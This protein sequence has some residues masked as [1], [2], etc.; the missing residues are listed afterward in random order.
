[1]IERWWVGSPWRAGACVALCVLAACGRQDGV[2][3][4]EPNPV[5]TGGT[6]AAGGATDAGG[7]AGTSALIP[8]FHAD[9]AAKA[10]FGTGN[11]V[12]G[13]STEFGV[14]LAGTDDPGTAALSFPG[15]PEYASTQ[16]AGADYVTEIASPQ[17]F[18]F[19]TFRTR[20]AFG[21]CQPTEEA[22]NAALGYFSDG[23]DA[24]NNGITD[25]EEIDLQVLCGTPQ[26]LS[27]TV[28][29][30]DQLE[31][32]G[33]EAF[34][35][36]SRV[37]DFSNGDVYDSPSAEREG[38]VKTTTSAAFVRPELFAPGAFYEMGFEWH[39]ASLR[40]FMLIDG[41]DV[42]LWTL[43]DPARIPQQP[44]T[45]VYNLWHPATHWYPAAGTAAFPAQP[46]V[47]HVDWFDYYAE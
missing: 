40:F 33:S 13:S 18:G 41:A 2:V 42:T 44:V 22:V 17:S 27:L 45:M 28:F 46:V 14:A 7:T 1:M 43:T 20:L 37:I 11:H 26:Y 16:N 8:T 25:D 5:G 24:N 21:G 36:L 30:D 34:R 9:F 4:V 6:V 47:M 10:G 19:G 32:N 3:G 38:F 15:H 29:T 31:S 23:T 35:K 39:A 12:P